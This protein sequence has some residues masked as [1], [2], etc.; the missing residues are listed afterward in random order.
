MSNNSRDTNDVIQCLE[1]IYREKQ[2]QLTINPPI[3]SKRH[4]LTEPNK[5]HFTPSS[6]DGR[7]SCAILSAVLTLMLGKYTDQIHPRLKSPDKK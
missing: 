7:Y 6:S 5:R 3:P 1:I 4:D 2:M